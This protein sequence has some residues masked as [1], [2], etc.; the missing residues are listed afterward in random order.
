MFLMKNKTK[1]KPKQKKKPQK[2]KKTKTKKQNPTPQTPWN[3][4]TGSA[5]H[6]QRWSFEKK[7]PQHDT[8]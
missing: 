3:Y 6:L 1:K 8:E 5:T 7:E 4:A 2:T